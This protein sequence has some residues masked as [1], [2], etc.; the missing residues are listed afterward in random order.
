MKLDRLAARRLSLGLLATLLLAALAWT[1][2]RTGPLAPTRV[3]VQRAGTEAVT[4]ALFGIGTVEARRAYQI[5]PAV[6]GRVRR[7]AVDVGDTVQ[8]GQL[9]AQMDPVDL[10][11]R[12]VGL[13]AAL[14]RAASTAVA[15]DAQR[16]DALAR[17][18]LAAENERRHVDLGARGFIST[19]AV[20]AKLQERA[21]ADAAVAA[22]DANLAAAR[23][24]L[25]RLDAER[26]ALRRQREQ[27]R[28][29]AP[30]DALVV[31]RDAEP[32][33]AVM[34]GQPVVRLVEPASL[35]VRT[36]FDQGRAAGLAVGLPAAVALRSN[37]DS[38]LAGRVAR[39]EAVSDSVTEERIVQVAVDRMPAG[40]SIGELAEVTVRLPPAPASLVVPNA[41]VR[42]RGDQTGVWLAGDG[43]PRFVPVRLGAAGLDGRVQV[44]DGIAAGDLVVVHSE[45]DLAANSRIRVVDALL[46]VRR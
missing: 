13:D 15:V 29:L 7:V 37:P 28:L 43:R 38:P 39:I 45:R 6:A 19:G 32:G 4:P 23:H 8:A 22:A 36:R 41:S 10:D 33:S 21:S 2:L 30:A 31:G 46:P 1:A 24:E 17:R 20:E 3:T 34:A 40:V 9:L 25:Q 27:L 14:A 42:Q 12:L 11:E 16:R 18:A 26:A 35:W 44:L 5:G